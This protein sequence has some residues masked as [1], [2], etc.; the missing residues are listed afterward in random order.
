MS[1]P[2]YIGAAFAEISGCFVVWSWWRAGASAWWLIPGGVALALF[3]Y[4]LALTPPG[5]AGRS[6]AAYGGVYIVASLVWLRL[7]E[8]DT[9]RATDL[10]GAALALA[11]ASV[12]LWGAR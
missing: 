8:H 10:A 9:L 12:I 4:L 2:L 3:A 1:L 7:V 6:F 11:G 5:F